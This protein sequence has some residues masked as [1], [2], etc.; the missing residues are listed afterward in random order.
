MSNQLYDSRPSAAAQEGVKPAQERERPCIET[1]QTKTELLDCL[2]KMQ[3][4][5]PNDL[6]V[7]GRIYYEMCEVVDRDPYLEYHAENAIAYRVIDRNQQVLIVPKERAVPES[8]PPRRPE[9]IRKTFHYLLLAGLGIFLAGLGAVVF[10]LLA[11]V[12]AFQ[13]LGQSRRRDDRVRAAVG[14]VVSLALFALGLA[15]V[16]LLWLHIY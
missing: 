6:A 5:D 3:E 16:Y 8:F 14:A 13:A 10:G 7:R 2:S 4:Q 9:P 11:L 15:L 1:A 12:A